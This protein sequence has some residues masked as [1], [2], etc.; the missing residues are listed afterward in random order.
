MDLL[1]EGELSMDPGSGSCSSVIRVCMS[2]KEE[3]ENLVLR[4]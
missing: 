1:D 3:Q 4:D 2:L